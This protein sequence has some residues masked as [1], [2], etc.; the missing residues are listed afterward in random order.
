MKKHE[1]SP[2]IHRKSPKNGE[3][4]RKMAKNNKNGKFGVIFWRLYKKLV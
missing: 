4:C 1:K 3:K 2:K